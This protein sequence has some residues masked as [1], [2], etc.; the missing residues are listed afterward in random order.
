M[1]HKTSFQLKNYK[2]IP[3]L[4][5]NLPLKSFMDKQQTA[6]VEDPGQKP[7]GMTLCDS[8]FT[9]IELLVVVLIIGILA[10]VALPQYQVAVA[11]SRFT[12][13]MLLV[14]SFTK[15]MELYYLANGSF[16]C[17]FRD[18]DIDIPSNCTLV[19]GD[20]SVAIC[21]GPFSINLCHGSDHDIYS[22]NGE[23]WYLGTLHY[24]RIAAQGSTP[25][26]SYCIAQTT[27]KTANTVCKSLGG[28]NPTENIYTS[29]YTTYQLQ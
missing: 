17:D 9:L 2:V 27:D 22:S 21:T 23:D 18:L 1:Q 20:P 11:K 26:S 28:T 7:S 19:S 4:I 3:N 14:D 8:G 5:W 16:S 10:A 13:Q 24:E 12:Q 29:G 25:S 6:I 15:A